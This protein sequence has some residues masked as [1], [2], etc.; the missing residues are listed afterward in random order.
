MLYFTH[1][2]NMVQAPLTLEALNLSDHNI[3]GDYT[4]GGILHYDLNGGETNALTI[5]KEVFSKKAYLSLLLQLQNDEKKNE[6][7]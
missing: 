5:A 4:T 2:Y 1:F 6:R 7:K 3:N